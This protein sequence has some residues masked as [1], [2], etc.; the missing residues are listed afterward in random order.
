MERQVRHLTADRQKNIQEAVKVILENL[1]ENPN[2]KGLL[3]TP[4]RVAK[5]YDEIFEGTRWTND[6]IAAEFG[7]CFE[8]PADAK[9]SM[10][11]MTNIEAF[12]YCEHHMALMYNMHVSVAY[13]PRNR[14]IGLSKIPRIVDLVTKRLQLQEK[15]GSDICEIL[16]KILDTKDVMTVIYAEHSCVTARGIKNNGSRTKTWTASGVFLRDESKRREFIQLINEK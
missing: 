1:G 6:E 2:R 3:E 7:K 10:V 16:Q 8:V 13:I 12:S 4:L 15:I 9:N 11:T 5:M 14:I